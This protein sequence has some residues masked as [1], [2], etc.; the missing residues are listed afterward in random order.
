[1]ISF[2]KITLFIHRWLGL[3]TGLVVFIVCI[4]GCLFAFQQEFTRWLRYDMM[5][6]NVKT[7]T[8]LPIK[9][10][11]KKAATALGIDHLNYGLI[12]YKN[13]NRNWS[14]I[15][16][17][18][19]P[20]SWT[21]F[22]SMKKYKTVYINPYTGNIAGI[23]NEKHDFFQ[24]V[25]GL[26]WSLLLATPIGQ[27]IVVW[28]T[29][30]FMVSLISG[31]ILWW[32]KRWNKTNCT[33]SF[34]IKWSSGWRRINYDLHNILRFYFVILALILG[35]TGL[36]WL[37]PN[38]TQKSLHF[39]GSGNFSLPQHSA[40]KIV[41]TVQRSASQPKP[42]QAAYRK[43]WL[44]FPK[45]SSIAI[46]APSDSKSPI[47]ATVRPYNDTYYAQSALQF[48]QHSGRLIRSNLY[49]AKNSGEKLIAMN[50][51]IHVGAIA[52]LPGKIIAFLVSLVSTSLPVTGF[53]IWWD[54]EK[55][56]WRKPL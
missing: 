7:N 17:R 9:E 33:K 14:A 41:S 15:A 51:D 31:F 35:F 18:L 40:K 25:K 19:T 56:K 29:V 20:N 12:T 13:P 4:T 2:K 36:Y 54:R 43:A 44:K 52:G 45:A 24:I 30:I 23:V 55:R 53:I 32:P 11:Q 16:Y 50:Y 26:H 1:M 49:R 38:F 21:Y 48:D 46:I 42:L 10:L 39:M 47:R 8:T 22:G 27:P 34:R 28:C 6:V 3:I 37:F 5:H